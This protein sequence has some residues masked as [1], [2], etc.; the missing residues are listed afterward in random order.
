MNYVYV[1][2]ASDNSLYTGWTKDLYQRF[3]KHCTKRGA[4]FTR[5]KKRLKLVYVEYFDM[6]QDARKREA[7]IKKMSKAQKEELIKK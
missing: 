7:E 1:L 5:S 3:E 6:E 4:R 2:R